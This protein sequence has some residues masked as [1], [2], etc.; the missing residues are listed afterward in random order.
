MAAAPCLLCIARS[1]LA[2][3]PRSREDPVF[4][5]FETDEELSDHLERVHHM[6]M[7]REGETKAETEHRFLVHHPSAHS[8]PECQAVGATWTP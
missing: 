3:I 4:E 5:V 6:P 8:C 7:Q 1:T 2:T